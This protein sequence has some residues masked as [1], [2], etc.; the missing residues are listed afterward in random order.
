V[1][2]PELF[3]Q[4]S[5]L[6]SQGKVTEAV[7]LYRTAAA[8][9]HGPSAKR[10]GDIYAGGKGDVAQDYTESLRWHARARQLGETIEKKGR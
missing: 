6:E 2:G 9:G 4:A 8:A 5:A 1:N 7:K 3:T 10:L